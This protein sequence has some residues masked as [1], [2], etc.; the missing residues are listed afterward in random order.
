MN[1]AL[2][3]LVGMQG[4]VC[5][6]RQALGCGVAHA[7]LT[8]AVQSGELVRVRRAAFVEGT[9]F[10]AARPDAR[11][12]LTVR[13]TLAS[14]V[15][16]DAASHHAALTLHGMPIFG[17]DTRRIDLVSDIKRTTR[18][19]C[20]VVHPRTGDIVE[21]G[22][23]LATDLATSLVRATVVTGVVAGVVAADRALATGRCSMHQLKL[24]AIAAMPVRAHRRLARMLDLVDARSESVAESRARLVFVDAAC[25]CAA[26]SRSQ[27][28]GPSW[29][30][31]TC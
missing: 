1:G 15:A 3:E 31:S 26:R 27:T 23:A 20:L 12:A 21:A 18:A 13:A 5:G 7:D 28:E 29:L 6:V 9:A 2:L 25:R 10:R 19:G 17:F 11:Y 14:R 24:A 4:G 22:G 8:A 16:A 30:A